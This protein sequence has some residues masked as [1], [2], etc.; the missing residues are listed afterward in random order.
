MSTTSPAAMIHMHAERLAAI[1]GE[2]GASTYRDA[3]GPVRIGTFQDYIAA[4]SGAGTRF[5][6]I[7]KKSDGSRNPKFDCPP[8]CRRS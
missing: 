2:E 8:P 7:A 3:T 4:T 5:A 1:V 6:R